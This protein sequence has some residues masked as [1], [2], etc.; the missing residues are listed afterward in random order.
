M[1]NR[2]EPAKVLGIIAGS[3][4][5]PVIVA[6]EAKKYG[7]TVVG[8]GLEGFANKNISTHFQ[9]Y[10]KTA[11]G[12]LG[13]CIERLKNFGA[14]QV[15]LCGHIDHRQVFVLKELDD[16][17]KSIL[18]KQDKRAETLLSRIAAA[19]E[20]SGLPVANLRQFLGQYLAGEGQITSIE[21]KAK[22][23]EDLDFAWP[24]ASQAAEINI[25]QSLVA[26]SGVIV[27]LEGAEGTD[28]MI[29]RG[30][31]LAGPGAVVVKLPMRNKDP[32]F[33]LPVVGSRTLRVMAKV[34]AG[35]LAIAADQTII[36]D[37]DQF[38]MLS[39]KEKIPVVARRLTW[40]QRS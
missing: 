22:T 33:D 19:I 16:L 38:M 29:R 32:R 25:G 24:L 3:G 35:L 39:E 36:I 27:A 14:Q 40:E 11:P 21:P 18:T 30:G 2:D 20:R 31:K 12:K 5:L 9:K 6:K 7:F 4:P 28:E 13:Y 17:M 10:D 26:K 1:R 23:L 34:G 8:I 37:P 15:A